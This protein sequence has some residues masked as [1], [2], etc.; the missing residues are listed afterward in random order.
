MGILIYF[1]LTNIQCIIPF[2]KSKTKWLNN[3]GTPNMFYYQINYSFIF[4]KCINVCQYDL[5]NV[6]I[7]TKGCGNVTGI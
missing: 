6:S 2:V 7:V 5:K 1:H 3:I 4:K